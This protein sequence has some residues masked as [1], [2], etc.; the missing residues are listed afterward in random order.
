MP[1]SRR[2]RHVY[3]VVRQILILAFIGGNLFSRI[4]AQQEPLSFELDVLP[5]LTK[6]GC[7]SGA[8]HGAV[9]GRG[10]FFLSLWGS[11]PKADYDQ[12]ARAFH[13]RR[14]RFRVPEESLLIAKPTGRIAHEGSERFQPDSPTADTL[15]SWIKAG[16]PYGKPVQIDEFLISAQAVDTPKGSMD[17]SL[18]AIAKTNGSSSLIDV[19]DRTAWETDPNGGVVWT[20]QSPPRI[21]LDRPGRHLITARF[22]GQVRS[23]V[24][25][26]P[27]PDPATPPSDTSLGRSESSDSWI[28]DEIQQL[29]EQ[30]NIRA[31]PTVDDLTWLRRVSLDLVGRIPTVEEIRAFEK[32][33]LA[34]RKAITVDGLIASESFHEYWTF[35]L[36]RW[37]GFRPIAS[38]PEATKAFE[39]YLRDRIA[40]RESWRII[41]QELLLSTGDTHQVGQANFG[42]LVSDPRAHAE[43]IS[44]VFLG[45]RLQCANCHNHP[46]DRWTQDDYHGLAA[47]LAGVERGRQV[48]YVGGGQV[49]NL[50]TQE[51]AIPRI[52]GKEF[53]PVQSDPQTVRENLQRLSQWI[54]DASDSDASDSDASDPK[55]AKVLANRLWAS[56]MG[57]GLIDPVDDIRDTNPATH[58]GLLDRLV[59]T[60][61]GSDYQPAAILKPIALSDAYAR[62]EAEESALPLD[63]SFYA[64]HVGK[65]LAPEVLYDAI[66]D[67]LGIAGQP[68]AIQ[69]LDPTTPSESLDILGRCGR[70][71]ACESVSGTGNVQASLAQKLHWI[72]GSLVNQAI[73]S[74]KNFLSTEWNNGTSDQAIL[75]LGYLRFLGKRPTQEEVRLWADQIPE[76]HA[77]KQAWFEDW[78]WSMLSSTRFLSN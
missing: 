70:P 18:N 55:F 22:A 50:R 2:D 40:K 7:N 36:A 64:A 47:I 78:A 51:P 43:L 76:G 68:R 15:I 9:A 16:A 45:V 13:S 44:R 5:L 25:I 69:W 73:A 30:A 48:R 71:T 33:D 8:C 12:I 72:N 29:L 3:F 10:Q 38:E 56:L 14:I 42:R 57:R 62:L 61:I 77:E 19:A 60:L 67:A 27:Y 74:Q 41:A 4:F 23:L 52:P 66:H 24:L 21:R 39:A 65:A 53:L 11:D 17:Y 6:H 32:L 63:P 49:T 58:P 54:L 37:L 28:D 46:L 26:A 1:P 31:R 20:E 34:N 75:E 35:K 59:Q